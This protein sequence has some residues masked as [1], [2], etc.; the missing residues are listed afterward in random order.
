MINFFGRLSTKK[1]RQQIVVKYTHRYNKDAHELCYDIGKAPRL[2]HVDMTCGFYYVV[3]EYIEGKK[4][5]ECDLERSAYKKIIKDIEEAITL[6]HSKD[7]VFADLRDTNILVFQDK[8]NEY[9]GMLVDFDW[10]G[11]NDVDSY[12]SLMNPDINWPTEA[13]DKMPLKI[14]H[15]IYWLDYV[16]EID[17]LRWLCGCPGKYRPN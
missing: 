13:K 11:V 2:L 1:D 6:L 3:M 7:I 5:S 8:D 4:L 10:A 12:P 17:L 14:E 16:L 15:D 9:R